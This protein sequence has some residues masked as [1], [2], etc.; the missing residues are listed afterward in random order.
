MKHFRYNGLSNLPERGTI[1]R[2]YIPQNQIEF[3][4][5]LRLLRSCHS[6]P[7]R[8]NRSEHTRPDLPTCSAAFFDGRLNRW[9]PV[10]LIFSLFTLQIRLH[11]VVQDKQRFFGQLWNSNRD[12]YELGF[13]PFHKIWKLML[14]PP[15]LWFS[16]GWGRRLGLG[17]VSGGPLKDHTPGHIFVVFPHDQ[18]DFT[19]SLPCVQFNF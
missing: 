8:G 17:E 15:H 9:L 6:E 10:D 13:I 1:Y 5:A 2:L 16:L 14:F 18:K 19:I 12:N 3:R 4:A 11:L 7:A